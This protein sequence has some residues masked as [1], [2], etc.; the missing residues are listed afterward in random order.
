MQFDFLHRIILVVTF[1][2]CSSATLA[3]EV[4]SQPRWWKG[5]L[6]S[7]SLWSDGDDYPEMIMDWYKSK[8]YHFAV[9]SDHNVI[10]IGE[11]WSDVETNAGGEEAYQKYL[12]R[13]G[14]AWVESRMREG[15]KQARLKPLSEYRPLFDEHGRFLIVQSQEVT[16]R[17]LTAPIHINVTHVR[18]LIQPQGGASVVEVMQNNIDA[19]L[20]QR[21]ASGQPMIPHV[22]H[23]NFGWGI[24]AEEFMQ[25]RGEKFF[26]VYNGH[27]SVRNEGDATHAGMERFWDIVLTWRLGILGLPVMYGIAT[28]DAH[29]Y[30]E[31]R[32]GLSNA[33]RGW[34]MVRSRFLTAE[35][36]IRSMEV[37]DFYASSGVSLESV[38]R[39]AKQ[40]KLTIQHEPGVH[41]TTFFVGTRKGFERAHEPFRAGDGNPVRNTHQYHESVGE[42]LAQTNDL[43]PTYVFQGDEIYVRAKVVSSKAMANPYRDGETE[44]AWVQP[45]VGPGF[46]D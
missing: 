39:N 42:V 20:A 6:H 46:A 3:E 22:N 28:D 18:S 29:N 10:Q 44:C 31:Q 35:H 40:L 37:G 9:L 41:Y 24:T 16:D 15:K 4:S 19:I 2:G 36:L 17:Y 38:D 11:K 25:L 34:V 7:H 27:P 43:S 32:V 45:L 5:N 23:P 30:H 33:G 13:F 12:N 26:E 14:A 1:V 8:E 21:E